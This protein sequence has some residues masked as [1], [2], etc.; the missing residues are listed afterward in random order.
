MKPINIKKVLLS[1]LLVFFVSL[2]NHAQQSLWVGQSYTFDVTSSVMGLTANTSWSTNDGYL[3]LSGSGFYRTITVTQYFSGTATVTCEWD[4]KLTSNSNYTHMRRDV[5]ITCRDNQVSISPT[6]LTLAP[7]QT[8]YVGYSHQYSNDYSSNANAYFQSSDPSIVKV[9]ERTGEVTAVSPGST[10]INVY[11]KISSVSPYCRVTVTEVQPIAV[12]IPNTLSCLAGDVKTLTASITP[13]NA[14]TTLTWSSSNTSVA[15]VSSNGTI[16]AM[17]PGT[18]NI[19][20]KTSNGLSSVCNL[21]VTE[22][23]FKL[24]S[25]QPSDNSSNIDVLS[26]IKAI[27]SSDIFSDTNFASIQLKD[28]NNKNVDGSIELSSSVLEFKPT[29]SLSPLTNYTLVIPK[30]SIKNK[31]GTSNADA[32]NINFTTGEKKKLTLSFNMMS[33]IVPENTS[34]TIAC[35]VSAAKIYYTIDGS[36]PTQNSNLYSAP[37]TIGKTQTVKAFA[38]LDGYISSDI[39]SATYIIANG[40]ATT[41]T[42][43]LSIDNIILDDKNKSPLSISLDNPDDE[44]SFVQFDLFLPDK[45]QFASQN[46]EISFIASERIPLNHQ[47]IATAYQ[48][49]GSARCIIAS[50]RNLPLT[51]NSGEIISFPLIADA[52]KY[53]GL[54]IVTNIQLVTPTEKLITP[55]TNYSNVSVDLAAGLNDIKVDDELNIRISGNNLILESSTDMVVGIYSISGVEITKIQLTAGVESR[56]SL[57]RGI[58]IVNHKK[59][60]I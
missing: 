57:S 6:S 27:F 26:S 55:S 13:T 38:V 24:I 39:V 2:T 41:S 48:T 44:I 43:Y 50:M 7:G 10:Y 53:D 1:F 49:D 29:L 42:A 52:G 31:W 36:I 5:T 3:S 56:V 8:G 46:D 45:A 23:T 32:Y 34:I 35:D 20:V 28:D 21:T 30:G 17:N 54:A 16:T 14:S 51:E 60:I 15:T 11:S 37:I 58:Y 40:D 18:T 4:Y 59:I 12:S 33:G 9:N 22:P 25:S 47:I 19:S